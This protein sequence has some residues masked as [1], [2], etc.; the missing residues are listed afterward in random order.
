MVHPL[1]PDQ[2]IVIT[3]IGLTAPNGNNLKEFR[4]SLLSGRS[5]VRPFETRYMGK[6]IAGVC[7]FD[8]LLY[9]KRKE[10]RRGTRAG[11]VSIYCAQEAVRDAGIDLGGVDRSRVGVYVGVTEHG[12]V[13][14]E[15]EVFN[16]SQYDYDTKFWSHHHNPRT[17]ANNPAGEVTLNMKITGPHYTIGAAC[18]AGNMGVIQGL[19]MLRLGEV[20]LALAGG[21]SE[22]IHTFG[23]FASF[24]S[25]GALASHEDPTKASRPFD[26]KRNGIV[27]SEGGCLYTLERLSDAEKR[28]AKVYAEIAGYAINSDAFDFILPEPGRQAECI[29]AALKKAGLAP[30]DID[31]L[32]THATA[33]PQGDIQECKAVRSVFGE[34]SGVW[35]NNTKSFI[36][37]TM[38]AAGTLELS[39]NLPAF[40]DGWVHPTINLDDLDPDCAL[41]GLVANAPKKIDRVEHIMNNSFG[42]FGINSVLIV[43]RFRG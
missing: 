24:K 40:D 12:N 7:D 21:V 31:I 1:S 19:Q 41:A 39:G 43:K 18:A 5:G 27:C 14:T 9:Q 6:V 42:M 38:G 36:G 4:Q 2:R 3:G 26:R 13:E 25:E 33:T 11:S 28:G 23:I 8:E 32:N 37:H 15:N 29:R 35:I 22:S 10:V 30:G 20:D 17:V 34:G 16:I